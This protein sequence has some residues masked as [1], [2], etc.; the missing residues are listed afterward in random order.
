MTTES[1]NF[2]SNHVTQLDTTIKYIIASFSSDKASCIGNT[3]L[4]SKNIAFE[5]CT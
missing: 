4:V 1:A 3:L 2:Y 5:L